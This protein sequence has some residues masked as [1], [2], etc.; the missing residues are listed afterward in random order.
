MFGAGDEMRFDMNSIA[1]I[2]TRAITRISSEHA[3]SDRHVLIGAQHRDVKTA[4]L[5]LRQLIHQHVA[6]GAD[7]SAEFKPPAQ[8]KCL[9][10]SAAVSE[11]RKVQVD[12]VDAGERKSARIGIVCQFNGIFACSRRGMVGSSY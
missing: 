6:G 2:R 3:F 5:H 9:A 8:E 12:S 7:F 1:L 11:F 10:E 4:A